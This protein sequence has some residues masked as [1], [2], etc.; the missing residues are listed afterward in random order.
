MT[1]RSETA[2]HAPRPSLGRGRQVHAWVPWFC[3]GLF[4]L[5]AG[6][7]C[8][9]SAHAKNPQS[10]S[11]RVSGRQLAERLVQ[12]PLVFEGVVLSEEIVPLTV[13]HD[14]NGGKEWLVPP[15]YDYHCL[16]VAVSRLHVGILP[17]ETLVVA[18][19]VSHTRVRDPDA[20]EGAKIA[21]FGNHECSAGDT[22]VGR[23][24]V[25]AG[26]WGHY[27]F[28]AFQLSIDILTGPFPASFSRGD[29]HWAA[30]QPSQLARARE[31]SSVRSLVLARVTGNMAYVSGVDSVQVEPLR[32]LYG[33]IPEISP[34]RLA[35]QSAGCGLNITLGDT[36]VLP[37]RAGEPEIGHFKP[38]C[39]DD[40]VVRNGFVKQF[41]CRFERIVDRCYRASAAGLEPR[42]NPSR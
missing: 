39:V 36:L 17:A 16:R 29:L 30:R 34:I 7:Q 35:F 23:I 38:L 19:N 32:S 6:S 31:L 1:F 4:L 18:V 26:F 9:S 13:L 42:L 5:L 2:S 10:T 41:G 21:F 11:L 15:I 37:L 33:P 27:Q 25:A 3:L 8:R 12:R 22:A 28:A 24:A 14:C 20:R 40:L